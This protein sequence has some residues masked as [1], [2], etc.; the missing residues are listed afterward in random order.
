[1]SAADVARR[2]LA[3][4]ARLV[5]SLAPALS[6]GCAGECRCRSRRDDA[7]GRRRRHPRSRRAWHIASLQGDDA[8]AIVMLAPVYL[9]WPTRFRLTDRWT[10]RSFAELVVAGM[11]ADDGVSGPIEVLEHRHLGARTRARAVVEAG[12]LETA[13][14]HALMSRVSGQVGRGRTSRRGRPSPPRWLWPAARRAAEPR[15]CHGGGDKN[16]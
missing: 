7:R 16:Y 2:S 1:M 12:M 4:R 15:A 13:D 5:V 9:A 11:L 8:P 3:G 6:P 14:G 10:G